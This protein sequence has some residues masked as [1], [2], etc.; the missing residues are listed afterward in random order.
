MIS[1]IYNATQL[2]PKYEIVEIDNN[3]DVNIIGCL[4]TYPITEIDNLYKNFIDNKY[5]GFNIILEN[6]TLYKNAFLAVEIN[7]KYCVIKNYFE[8]ILKFIQN[9]NVCLVRNK[10]MN[11]FYKIKSDMIYEI[12]N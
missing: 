2:T 7:H 9:Y 11:D 8:N 12:E 6:G 3:G 10:N 1:Y 4:N 5:K